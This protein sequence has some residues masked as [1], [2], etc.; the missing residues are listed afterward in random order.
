MMNSAVIYA[1]RTKHSQK[2]AEAIG[3][4]LSVDAK[5]IAKKPALNDVELLFSLAAYMGVS[6]CRS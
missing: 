5:N 2:L 4:F 6:V 3:R 1:T